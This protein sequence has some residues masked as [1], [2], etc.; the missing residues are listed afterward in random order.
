MTPIVSPRAYVMPEPVPET[1]YER[2]CRLV[3][4][5]AELA[6]VLGV[7][8]QAV[9]KWRQKIPLER[10]PDLVRASKWQMTPHDFR[11]D[12]FPP[13]FMFPA[14]AFERAAA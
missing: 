11:P 8:R 9:S 1:P 2:L 10:V 5:S 4:S 13:G 14:E 12:F 3:G 7:S 6:R